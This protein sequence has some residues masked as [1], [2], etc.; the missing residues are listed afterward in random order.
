MPPI[1][2]FGLLTINKQTVEGTPATDAVGGYSL[3]IQSGMISPQAE[4]ADLPRSGYSMVRQGRYKQRV[5]I[6][7]T[8]TVLAHPDALGLLL[9]LTMGAEL[10]LG[11]VAGGLTPHTFVMADAWPGP[12]TVWAS[13]GSGADADVWRFTDAY[14]SRLRITGTSGGI[15]TVDLDFVAKSYTKTAAGAAGFPASYNAA[16]VLFPAEPRFKYIGS[17]LKFDTDSATPTIMDNAETVEIEIDRNPEVR[18]GPSLTPTVI[19]PDRMVNVNAEFMYSTGAGGAG[20]TAF[21]RQGWNFLEDSYISALGSA[22]DQTTP[23]GSFDM[24][25]GEHPGAPNPSG[26][27]LRIVSGGGA[28]L[29]TTIT[30]QQNWE[31]GV[32]RPDA[33]DPPTLVTYRAEGTMKLPAAGTTEIVAILNS[34]KAALYSA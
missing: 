11:T 23:T 10:T 12:A 26:G 30:P 3:A 34:S 20:P 1:R 33:A 5:T 6:G 9:Y 18:Y 28:T 8:V 24:T 13:I 7:G 16:T 21:D 19:A 32:N 31:Y 29:P 14:I 22:P 15:Y 27:K 25:F 4:F 17:V 2:S